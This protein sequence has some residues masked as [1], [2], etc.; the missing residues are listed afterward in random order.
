MSSIY[1]K[2]YIFF[3]L[4]CGYIGWRWDLFSIFYG[5][6]AVLV[7]SFFW[8]ISTAFLFAEQVVVLVYG[9]RNDLFSSLPVLG[10]DLPQ[11][12]HH[13]CHTDNSVLFIN[14]L[15]K[16]WA[17]PHNDGCGEKSFT[18]GS[19]ELGYGWLGNITFSQLSSEK[20]FKKWCRF[21]IG[22]WWRCWW[23]SQEFEILP[24][25]D[26]CQWSWGGNGEVVFCKT[27]TAFQLSYVCW[28]LYG[29][30]LIIGDVHYRVRLWNSKVLS[31]IPLL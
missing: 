1:C 29:I 14:C 16:T 13:L 23:C 8:W 7:A 18:G 11:G 17:E 31:D 9:I 20:W 15:D 4:S 2:Y 22:N 21:P 19:V 28:A 24:Y 3:S 26:S 6:G 25:I 10:L 5:E 12:G 27:L 30:V